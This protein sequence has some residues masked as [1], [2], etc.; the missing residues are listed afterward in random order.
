LFFVF[1]CKLTRAVPRGSFKI[2]SVP[3]TSR[4]SKVICSALCDDFRSWKACRHYY[5]RKSEGI[6]FHRSWFVCVS[7]SVSVCDHDD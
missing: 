3:R 5:T 4:S 6:C 7:L 1:Y 2:I